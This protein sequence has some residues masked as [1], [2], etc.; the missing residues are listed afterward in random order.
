MK[1]TDY[2]HHLKQAL[3]AKRI[4]LVN[5]ALGMVIIFNL[6]KLTVTLLPPDPVKPASDH[7]LT[8]SA[9]AIPVPKIAS[10][11]LF[12]AYQTHDAATLPIAQLGLTV[13]GIFYAEQASAAQAIIATANNIAKL[14]KVGD[15]INGAT[16]KQILPTDIVL[17]TGGQLQRLPLIRPT[18]ENTNIAPQE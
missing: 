3:L 8:P 6:L 9:P 7:W 12:G 13:Q 5:G 16:I 1:S 15:S 10:L 17:E 14:Y 4:P 18:L 2:L 11:H